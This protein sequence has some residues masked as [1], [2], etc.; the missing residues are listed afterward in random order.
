MSPTTG[1]STTDMGTV[2]TL[3][4]LAYNIFDDLNGDGAVSITDV[5]IARSRIGTSSS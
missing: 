3:T 5:M 4:V 2:F 1:S